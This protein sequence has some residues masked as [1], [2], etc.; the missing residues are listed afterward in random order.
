MAQIRP[1]WLL[2]VAW[3]VA[4]LA[5]A[6]WFPRSAWRCSPTLATRGKPG[7]AMRVI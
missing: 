7:A 2:G 4:A 1:A 6:K 3:C 5:S